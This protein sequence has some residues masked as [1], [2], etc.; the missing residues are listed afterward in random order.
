VSAGSN[1]P[2]V[3]TTYLEHDSY[4]QRTVDGTPACVVDLVVFDEAVGIWIESQ[5]SANLGELPS[6]GRGAIVMV[7]H[8]S[9]G[10]ATIRIGID[11]RAG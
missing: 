8:A 6:L 1:A 10:V 7:F 3:V 11:A 9:E 5:R 2:A 4:Q